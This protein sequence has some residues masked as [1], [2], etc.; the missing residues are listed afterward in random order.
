M[1]TCKRDTF[2]SGA[3]VSEKE[4]KGNRVECYICEAFFSKAKLASHIATMHEVSM[5]R[6]FSTCS[7]DYVCM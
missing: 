2:D 5:Y 4:W 7:Y 1:K 6:P 3:N